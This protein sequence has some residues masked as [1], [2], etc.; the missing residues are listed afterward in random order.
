MLWSV[1]FDQPPVGAFSS[2]GG[3]LNFLDPTFNNPH[4]PS[5][6]SSSSSSPA[7]QPSSSNT[8]PTLSE[9]S[10][11]DE[12]LPPPPHHASPSNEGK[13]S[14]KG[15]G[16]RVLVGMIKG[17]P[18]ALPADHLV[19]SDK[20]LERALV[21]GQGRGADTCETPIAVLLRPSSAL[22]PP[23]SLNALD[24]SEMIGEAG[25]KVGEAGRKIEDAWRST[26]L[27]PFDDAGS[28]ADLF[29]FLHGEPSSHGASKGKGKGGIGSQVMIDLAE[30]QMMEHGRGGKGVGGGGGRKAGGV[31]GGLVC[32][33]LS[34]SMHS[35]LTLNKGSS[36][37]SLFDGSL[38]SWLPS[39][40]G[41]RNLQ[42]EAKK[43]RDDQLAID[44]GSDPYLNSNSPWILFFQPYALVSFTLVAA[45]LLSLFLFSMRKGKQ[46]HMMDHLD[47]QDLRTSFDS[48]LHDAFIVKQQP[49]ESTE[50][51][52]L[53]PLDFSSILPSQDSTQGDEDEE[54]KAI[55]ARKAAAYR[56]ASI[57]SR[58]AS[59]RYIPIPLL[60]APSNLNLSPAGMP[61]CSRM[62]LSSLGG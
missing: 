42:E 41:N 57:S 54:A 32:L 49:K 36:S 61:S 58:Q 53:P 50:G 19:L 24:S 3:G 10:R 26:A 44:K 33:Q 15:K 9:G 39:I 40:I 35:N 5:A 30:S 4:P 21:E 17:S 47:S 6:S 38:P 25:K 46:R 16:S 48:P 34:E 23:P 14:V 31:A 52:T 29:D 18:Y 59:Y 51:L 11:E 22:P 62:D 37:S 13:G 2:E 60:L 1:T 20:E 8:L 27:A 43:R 56:S 55:A 12:G 7:I 28:R 45:I